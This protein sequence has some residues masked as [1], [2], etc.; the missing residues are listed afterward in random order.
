MTKLYLRHPISNPGAIHTLTLM[1]LA[2]VTLWFYH[3]YER[4]EVTSENL[5]PPIEQWSGYQAR[6]NDANRY[7]ITNDKV[8][9]ST[10]VRIVIPRPESEYLR[11]E[12]AFSLNSVVPDE[13]RWQ[14]A[15]AFILG[16]E[17]S[18]SKWQRDFDNHLLKASGTQ[19][20]T[21]VLTT[22]IPESTKS[23]E[24]I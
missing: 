9:K 6:F 23:Y 4:F 15:R 8:G 17:D 10:G 19:T 5:L 18:S 24:F 14:V 3:G 7:V 2:G 1:L 11:L 16:R 13:K 22:Q 20:I 21:R 12:G